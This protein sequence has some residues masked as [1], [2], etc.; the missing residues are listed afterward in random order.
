MLVVYY[1]FVGIGLLFSILPVFFGRRDIGSFLFSLAS[2][3]SAMWI[4]SV[5]NI[6]LQKNVFWVNAAYVFSGAYILFNVLFA[7]LYPVRQVSFGRRSQYIFGGFLVFYAVLGLQFNF[8][9][10]AVS[11][12]FVV[13][14]GKG[15]P[16]AIALFLVS[17]VM[18]LWGSLRSFRLARYQDR[19]RSLYYFLGMSL[20]FSFGSGFVFVMPVLVGTSQYSIYAPLL[21]PVMMTAHFYSIFKY[22]LL[23]IRI[24]VKR[25][26]V[27]LVVTGF[28]SVLFFGLLF[29]ATEYIHVTFEQEVVVLL[30]VS[31]FI[32]LVY[33]LFID[34]LNDLTDRVFFRSAYD[35]QSVMG[36][37]DRELLLQRSA[38]DIVVDL[39][40][41]IIKT[42]KPKVLTLFFKDELGRIQALSN[43]TIQP[44]E[45]LTIPYKEL[46][47]DNREEIL[48][49][50]PLDR[51]DE[52]SE[53]E[54]IGC[55]R[56]SKGVQAVV[57]FGGRLSEMAYQVKDQQLIQSLL[58][59]T[60]VAL[61]HAFHYDDIIRYSQILSRF[62]LLFVSMNPAMGIRGLL[63]SLVPLIQVEFL[64]ELVLGF[65][66]TLKV[67]VLSDDPVLKQVEPRVLAL[68]WSSAITEK[69]LVSDGTVYESIELFSDYPDLY[70]FCRDHQFKSVICFRLDSGQEESEV[71][72]SFSKALVSDSMILSLL[73]SSFHQSV[74]SLYRRVYLYDKNIATKQ[75]NEDILQRM[76]VGILVFDQEGM[77]RHANQELCRILGREESSVLGVSF[78]D[79]NLDRRL[80]SF[81]QFSS[82]SS[83]T[84]ALEFS[85]G[86]DMTLSC[87]SIK[88]AHGSELETVCLLADISDYRKLERKLEHSDRLA[89]LSN[90]SSGVSKEIGQPIKDLQS[91]MVSLDSDWDDEAK[92]RA[93]AQEISEKVDQINSLCQ[94]LLRLG[95]PNQ[96]HFSRLNVV[97]L[98]QE[99]KGLISGQLNLKN[100]R[101]EDT[102]PESLWVEG[103]YS[104]LLQLLLN[105]LMNAIESYGPDGGVVRFEMKETE[106]DCVIRVQDEGGGLSNEALSK[107]FDPF[108]TSK[109][110]KN[111]LGLTISH[112]IVEDH[113]GRM[114]FIEQD[115]GAMI[116]I[117]IP[118]VFPKRGVNYG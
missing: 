78:Q 68:N 118:L 47:H 30:F 2:L 14:Y 69:V 38:R 44:I 55:I 27:Y 57:C 83:Q 63:E 67:S 61:D 99:A 62:N 10:T 72:M 54:L 19:M 100:C 85:I 102:I 107:A 53:I 46:F 18:I 45:Q 48:I 20:S 58:N 9:A 80:M 110:K 32:V 106:T 112:R 3:C 40:K 97:L 6:T 87:S 75:Y 31:L 77:I 89:S 94:S 60:A 7:W 73:I 64:G 24:I 22:Q 92:I 103:D 111:G 98:F 114:Q 49:E 36:N 115:Q 96:I 104:Q 25:G 37:Y 42:L 1:S 93:Y 29:V 11:D 34:Y 17:I 113:H 90:L 8:F 81:F 71:L 84:T 108:Y 39:E 86:T 105:V 101:L 41:V 28:L 109:V 51:Y 15:Q 74:I 50:G 95:K 43:G 16:I 116:E 59:R 79:L 88:L 23:D 26:F 52:A 65:D 33:P 35:Y 66:A 82:Q 76:L 56:S 13:T 117:V 70:K 5:L 21:Y 4:Y 91:M 12:D